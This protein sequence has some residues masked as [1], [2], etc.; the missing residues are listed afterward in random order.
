MK[1][2]DEPAVVA[3]VRERLRAVEPGSPRRWGTLS[4]HEMLCHLGDSFATAL[5]ERPV[6][7]AESWFRRTAV[8]R[9]ALW[10]PIRW[11]HGVATQRQADPK[12]EGTRPT[13]FAADRQ[14][15]EEKM[16]DFRARAEGGGYGRH[17]MFGAMS[18]RDWLRWGYLHCDHHLRQ[19]G[20]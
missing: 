3:A 1:T 2:L 15:V 8:K 7:D 10:A 6:E 12:R 17:P 11:P 14:R 13:V 19:F 16:D 4:A 18:T 20:V 5:G 9:L